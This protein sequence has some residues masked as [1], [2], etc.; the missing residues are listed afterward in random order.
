MK[1]IFVQID[2]LSDQGTQTLG[3][4]SVVRDFNTLF[5][6]KTLELGW[7]DNEVEKSCIPSGTYTVV[8]H[9]SPKFGTCFHVQ[10]VPNRSAILFHA[11]NFN[12]DT[13]GCILVG[14]Q[15]AKLNNDTY[16][17]VTNSKATMKRLL[18]V[19]PDEFECTIFPA[20]TSH[21]K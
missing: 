4:L 3:L 12:T 18:E 15:F 17:D 13:H 21:G 19:L 1:P 5:K 16:D 10:N 6:C 14:E 7:H 11:G 9:Q 8:K 20:Q 2:R